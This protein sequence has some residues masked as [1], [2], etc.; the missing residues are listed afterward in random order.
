MR[1]KITGLSATLNM[2]GRVILAKASLS[3]ILS[4]IMSYIKLPKKTTKDLVKIT[5][6][7]IWGSSQEKKKMHLMKWDTITKPKEHEALGLHKSAQ[8]N[9]V[10]L[11]RLS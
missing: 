9:K 3:G 8:R 4:H 11:G 2:A 7:F 5:R 6:D 10:I 1:K